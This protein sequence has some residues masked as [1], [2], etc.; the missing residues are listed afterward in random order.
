MDESSLRESGG[1]LT[2]C[3]QAVIAGA[4]PLGAEL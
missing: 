3:P 2:A 4:L 1:I